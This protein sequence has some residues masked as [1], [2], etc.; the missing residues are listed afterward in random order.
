MPASLATW[1]CKPNAPAVITASKVLDATGTPWERT[2]RKRRTVAAPVLYTVRDELLAHRGRVQ[3][4]PSD[5][6]GLL[7]TPPSLRMA[8]PI[9]GGGGGGGSIGTITN[10]VLSRDVF[11]AGG[12]GT[13]T[14]TG[15][16]A[17][18]W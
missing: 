15:L 6:R 18:S 14:V 9:G 11:H 17:V 8:P 12:G 2:K 3:A 4:P 7:M 16:T 5:R 10:A 13:I 1:R